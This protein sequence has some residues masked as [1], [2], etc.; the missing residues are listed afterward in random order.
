MPRACSGSFLNCLG[1]LCV[2]WV[3]FVA[4]LCCL[5]S[6]PVNISSAILPEQTFEI[7]TRLAQLGLRLLSD[8]M[9]LS[10][11]DEESSGGAKPAKLTFGFSHFD[12][13]LKIPVS[14]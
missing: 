13:I 10:L 1:G 4:F 3:A 12:M 6:R 11:L 8:S 5:T 14:P 9:A 2:F 7:S